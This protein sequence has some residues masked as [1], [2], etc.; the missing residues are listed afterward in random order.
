MNGA[1]HI[2]AIKAAAA[3]FAGHGAAKHTPARVG[4]DIIEARGLLTHYLR[5][6]LNG[7]IFAP[8]RDGPLIHEEEERAIRLYG[9]TANRS[10]LIALLMR[11]GIGIIA[12]ETAVGNVAPVE[13]PL[14]GVP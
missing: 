6:D 12:E 5:D 13:T 4:D 3:L 11:S 10:A 14:D 7:P 8:E 2:E 1:V 9:E